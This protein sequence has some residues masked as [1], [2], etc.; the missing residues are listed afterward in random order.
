MNPN[1]VVVGN[2]VR[3][4]N[5][6]K[7]FVEQLFHPIGGGQDVNEFQSK[8]LSLYEKKL[9]SQVGGRTA[10]AM[11]GTKQSDSTKRGEHL[12]KSDLM[13][14]GK[15]ATLKEPKPRSSSKIEASRSALAKRS[16]I[17]SNA[18]VRS[19][20]QSPMSPFATAS[21]YKDKMWGVGSTPGQDRGGGTPGA[22]KSMGT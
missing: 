4:L 21:D 6:R 10:T 1:K 13:I 18:S 7:K 11:S 3:D 22:A 16:K 20:N 19:G 5:E 17:Q 8:L 2:E 9:A 12:H 14:S 15:E